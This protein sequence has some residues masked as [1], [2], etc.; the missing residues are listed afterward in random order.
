MAIFYANHISTWQPK[1]GGVPPKPPPVDVPLLRHLLEYKMFG[2]S[3]LHAF[4]VGWRFK[5]L[6]QKNF[7]WSNWSYNGFLGLP[8][9]SSVH[10]PIA[11]VPGDSWLRKGQQLIYE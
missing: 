8:M 11:N 6:H 1:G 7:C 5:L 3:Y 2:E 4:S 10:R 9:E